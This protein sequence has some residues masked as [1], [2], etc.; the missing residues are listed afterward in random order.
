M[1]N[2]IDNAIYNDMDGRRHTYMEGWRDGR[3]DRIEI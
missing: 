3:L 1:D 2:D